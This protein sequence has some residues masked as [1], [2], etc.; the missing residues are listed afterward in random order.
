MK[1]LL[2]PVHPSTVCFTPLSKGCS[3]LL[4]RLDE[5]DGVIV[6]PSSSSSTL[7]SASGARSSSDTGTKSSLL[8]LE[9]TLFSQEPSVFSHSEWPCHWKGR[10]CRGSL[11]VFQSSM[12]MIG[13]P[14][15]VPPIPPCSIA[16]DMRRQCAI[17]STGS[18]WR[19]QPR[20][21]SLRDE[22]CN[23][24]PPTSNSPGG[25]RLH[26]VLSGAPQ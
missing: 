20:S 15:T 7:R 26:R 10:A 23:R 18:M 9:D 2:F 3:P 21:R 8:G 12:R 4:L 14:S 19:L 25:P 13:L 22:P 24:S 16:W 6:K 17:T 5:E 1:V 11:R